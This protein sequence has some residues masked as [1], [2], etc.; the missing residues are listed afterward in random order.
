VSESPDPSLW[1]EGL[2]QMCRQYCKPILRHQ[3]PD[4]SE[5]ARLEAFFEHSGAIFG[6]S[7]E[8][9]EEWAWGKAWEGTELSSLSVILSEFGM[10]AMVS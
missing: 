2:P 4:L 3:Q 5:A 6:A 1:D 7:P 9:R 10:K 8:D